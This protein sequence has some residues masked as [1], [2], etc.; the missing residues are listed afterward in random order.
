MDAIDLLK[1]TK[2]RN[3]EPLVSDQITEVDKKR[4]DM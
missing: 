4:V 2:Q 1:I 3:M